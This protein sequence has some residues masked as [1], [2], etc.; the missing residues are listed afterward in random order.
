[1]F[2]RERACSGIFG[3]RIFYTISLML[4]R[5]DNFTQWLDWLLFCSMA[6]VLFGFYNAF[7]L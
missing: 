4:H 7:S 2:E 5:A 1:M 3:I 6:V